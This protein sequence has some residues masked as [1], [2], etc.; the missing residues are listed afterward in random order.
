MKP[1]IAIVGCGTVG[2][3]I[4]KLLARAGYRVSGVATRSKK[5]AVSAAKRIGAEGF[6]ACPWEISKN[7]RIVFITTPDDAIQRTCEAISKHEG[8]GKGNVVIH[9]SGALSSEILSSARGCGAL[10][11]TLHPLQA[12]ASV[13]QAENLLQ[14]TFWTVEGDHEAMHHVQQLVNDL[15]GVLLEISAGAKSVYHAAAVT[16]S[17]YLVTLISCALELGRVAGLSPEVSLKAL[18]PLIKGTVSNVEAR[19][20]P[21]ALTGP[22]ARGDVDTVAAHLKAISGK[23]PRLLDMYKILGRYTIDLAKE[24]GTLDKEAAER[25]MALLGPENP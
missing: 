2:T 8:F 16:A 15:G 1:A 20:I 12:F 3:A 13:D 21:G 7:A 14:S 6:S 22:I 19:G 10:V 23:S 17:N 24:K 18:L 5:T 4:G 9:C 25:L 11:A